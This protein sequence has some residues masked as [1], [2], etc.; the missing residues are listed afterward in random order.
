MATPRV[1]RPVRGSRTGRPVMVLLDFLGRR[2]SLRL[3]WELRGGALG[4]RE[5]QRRSGISS[6]NVVLN[7]LK[8]GLELGLFDRDDEGR[9]QMTDRGRELCEILRPLDTWAEA[10]A[11]RQTRRG[12]R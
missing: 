6:P 4:F 12:R 8:E 5:L 9:Y 10:W 7:R 2:G 3:S 1:G 11:R